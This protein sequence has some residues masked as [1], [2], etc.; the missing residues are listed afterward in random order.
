M[1]LAHYRYLSVRNTDVT[2]WGTSGGD[3]V[4]IAGVAA[5]EINLVQYEVTV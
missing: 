1:D 2:D 4:Y 3:M 5:A